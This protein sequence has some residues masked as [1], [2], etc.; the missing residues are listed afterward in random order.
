MLELMGA[1]VLG[2]KKMSSE[3]RSRKLL[4]WMKSMLSTK[5]REIP[6]PNSN[7]KRGEHPRSL[8]ACPQRLRQDRTPTETPSDAFDASATSH[9]DVRYLEFNVW[10]RSVRSACLESTTGVA[11]RS[12][13]EGVADGG[14]KQRAYYSV[15]SCRVRH[16]DANPSIM[17]ATS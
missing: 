16:R 12:G 9:A 17:T 5:V 3:L 2:L 10:A 4:N 1:E 8:H 14:G 15:R 11:P 6:I 7:S 13:T